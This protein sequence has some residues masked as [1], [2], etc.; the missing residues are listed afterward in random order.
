MSQKIHIFYH[1]YC[2]K[3]ALDIITEQTQHILISGLYNSVDNI[4]CFLTGESEYIQQCINYIQILGNKYKIAEVGENDRSY[5]RFT[6]LKI[7]QYIKSGDKLLY[8]HNKGTT[9]LDLLEIKYWKLYMEY[10][11]MTHHKQCIKDLDEYEAVGI[12][13][14]TNPAPHFSGNFWWTTADYFFKLPNYI[15]LSPT[16]PEFFIAY[17]K[18]KY[19]SYS[20]TEL[21]L[22]HS[23]IFPL[24]YVD[25]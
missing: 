23:K 14:H 19:K 10:F 3:N 24:F 25:K 6:L 17:A 13:W 12:M 7:K 15:G 18:P 1:I 21:N 4:Y 22:Y 11:L 8:I 5:E 9:K 16:D 20:D 2:N